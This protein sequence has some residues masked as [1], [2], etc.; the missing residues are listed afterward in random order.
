MTL[1]ALTPERRQRLPVRSN[2][3][4]RLGWPHYWLLVGIL[5]S[6]LALI[7]FVMLAYSI[8]L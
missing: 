7:A 4:L 6:F 1:H 3:L 5:G 8:T 2:G